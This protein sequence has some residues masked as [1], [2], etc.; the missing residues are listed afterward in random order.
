MSTHHFCTEDAANYGIEEAIILQNIGYWS[1]KNLA[2][3]QNIKKGRVWTY[4]T[5]DAFIE[6]FP[7]LAKGQDIKAKRVKI[8]RILRSLEDQGAIVSEQL[9]KNRHDRTKWYSVTDVSKLKKYGEISSEA[10][11]TLKEQIC[12]FDRTEMFY[13]ENKS[14]PSLT[15]NKQQI[16]NTTT[17]T[18]EERA[19]EK[20][21]FDDFAICLIKLINDMIKEG[22]WVPKG[23]QVPKATWLK[24]KAEEL[25]HRLPNPSPA[26]CSV[27]ILRDWT[28][29]IGKQTDQ[30]P[31]IRKNLDGLTACP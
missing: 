8:G 12:S 22:G 21:D 30:L 31:K 13:P 28:N 9:N 15:D 19:R 24:S 27:L 14:V 3:R 26:D 17:T 2:N 11:K 18:T 4:N 23:Q 7:Y 29:L 6:L 1:C 5:R 25:Y 20:L 16:E 10:L